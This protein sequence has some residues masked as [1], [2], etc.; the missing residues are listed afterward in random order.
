MTITRAEHQRARERALE[1]FTKAHIALRDDE[2]QNLEIADFG[3]GDLAHYG[4]ELAM[5]VNTDRVCGKEV[6]LLPWQIC[7]E[8]RH[9]DTAGAV[10]KEETFRCR[11]GTVYLYVDGAATPQPMARVPDNRRKYH[12]VWHQVILQPGEQCTVREN[13]L[14]WFQAGEEGAVLSEFSTPSTDED[15]VFT[16]PDV[17]RIPVVV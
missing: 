15:D 3:L 11:W 5:Y 4:V 9:P 13:H 12:T 1:Y 6:I 17:K 7:P 16:D 10:G 14:H 8:H 2:K